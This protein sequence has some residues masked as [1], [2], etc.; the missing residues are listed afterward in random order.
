[1]L[2]NG[3]V[4][5]PLNIIIL[6]FFLISEILLNFLMNNEGGGV[7]SVITKLRIRIQEDIYL[8][9]HNTACG[10]YVVGAPESNIVDEKKSC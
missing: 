9:I 4:I 3:T 6:N 10:P 7:V 2:S 8:R 1:M 5:K